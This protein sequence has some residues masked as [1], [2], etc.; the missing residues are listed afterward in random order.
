MDSTGE[1]PHPR[2]GAQAFPRPS[3]SGQLRPLDG[4]HARVLSSPDLTSCFSPSL[5]IAIL[6]LL[7][8]M[9]TLLGSSVIPAIR[10]FS[11][12]CDKIREVLSL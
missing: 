5:T 10:V 7:V 2:G 6:S 12:H 4:P 11:V 3:S 9:T 8:L 1:L